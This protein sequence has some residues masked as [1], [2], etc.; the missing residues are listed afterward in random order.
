M[1]QNDTLIAIGRY[2]ASIAHASEN[3]TPS[4][5]LLEAMDNPANFHKGLAKTLGGFNGLI[6]AFSESFDG[7]CVVESGYIDPDD[8]AIKAIKS[9]T[10]SLQAFLTRLVNKKFSMN[11]DTSCE[12]LLDAY[13]EAIT[14]IASLAETL[15][16]AR[17]KIIKHDLAA[18]PR[19]KTL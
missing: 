18:E 12:L 16:E 13:S 9:A 4:N 5:Q 19:M 3:A 2:I 10:L 17:L 15:D 1:N 14:A 6:D 8:E 11:K 7:K